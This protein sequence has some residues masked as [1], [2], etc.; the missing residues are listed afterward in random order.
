MASILSTT[1]FL[2]RST[3]DEAK[4]RWREA[5]APGR[6]RRDGRVARPAR[7]LRRA[8]ARAVDRG[9]LG[10]RVLRRLLAVSVSRPDLP[11]HGVE[12]ASVPHDHRLLALGAGPPAP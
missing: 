1:R 8:G 2:G 7:R 12:E 5:E 6:A 11:P 3:S 9:G 4:P 10:V